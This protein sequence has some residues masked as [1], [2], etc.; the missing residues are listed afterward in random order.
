MQR[1][2]VFRHVA[3]T[4]AEKWPLKNNYAQRGCCSAI[5]KKWEKDPIM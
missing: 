1:R 5:A 3:K 4:Q 2:A